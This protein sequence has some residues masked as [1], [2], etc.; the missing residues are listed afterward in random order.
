[1]DCIST[2]RLAQYREI[3]TVFGPGTATLVCPQYGRPG[4]A[5]STQTALCGGTHLP[6]QNS[7][8]FQN[9]IISDV[10]LSL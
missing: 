8:S 6:K 4:T 3:P 5:K 2:Y 7:V 9:T 10:K 1:M